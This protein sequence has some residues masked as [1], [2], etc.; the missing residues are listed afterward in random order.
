MAAEHSAQQWPSLLM[1]QLRVQ[2]LHT[3]QELIVLKDDRQCSVGNINVFRVQIG[4]RTSKPQKR[5]GKL[6]AS[7]R[8]MS[9]SAGLGSHV[10]TT[11]MPSTLS[12]ELPHSVWPKAKPPPSATPAV[13]PV[14]MGFTGPGASMQQQQWCQRRRHVACTCNM[15]NAGLQLVHLGH[16]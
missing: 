12:T 10:D 6:S 5:S 8:T 4:W 7:T 15:L 3:H 13:I 16:S 14:V 1:K 2:A 11:S 9:Q